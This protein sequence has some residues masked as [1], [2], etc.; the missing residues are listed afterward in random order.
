[1]IFAAHPLL[2]FIS[3]EPITQADGEQ[4]AFSTVWGVTCFFNCM[5]ATCFFNCISAPSVFPSCCKSWYSSQ[6]FIASN[7]FICF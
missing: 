3:E 6:W 7:G 5:G 2:I 1:M 4:R